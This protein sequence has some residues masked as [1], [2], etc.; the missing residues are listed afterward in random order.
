MVMELI[1]SIAAFRFRT[2]VGRLGSTRSNFHA[3]ILIHEAVEP[4]PCPLSV[5]LA[6]FWYVLRSA[7]FCLPNDRKTRYRFTTCVRHLILTES[8]LKGFAFNFFK[9]GKPPSGG[10]SASMRSIDLFFKGAH[11]R[12]RNQRELISSLL[13]SHPEASVCHGDGI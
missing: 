6:E 1:P 10:N 8:L 13:G 3:A 7:E 12:M 9:T 11:K 2:F 5:T 4:E